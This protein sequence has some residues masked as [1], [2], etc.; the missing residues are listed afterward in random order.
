MYNRIPGLNLLR[1]MRG[2][3]AVAA[4]M[5]SAGAR[6]NDETM[7]DLT[8]EKAT[9]GGTCSCRTIEDMTKKTD[10]EDQM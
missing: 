6:P 2:A 7:V 9:L 5:T 4:E 3:E 8:M 10:E 1:A